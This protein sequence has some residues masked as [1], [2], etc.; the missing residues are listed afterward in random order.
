MY[1]FAYLIGRLT[2]DPEVNKT[3]SGKSVCN[4]TLA[5]QRTYKNADG[6][7]EADFIRC[8]LWDAIAN[9]AAEFCH[10]GDLIAVRGQ[11]RTSSY[12]DSKNEKKHAT[13]LLV[14]RLC[15]LSTKSEEKEVDSKDSEAE[16]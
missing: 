16:N 9:N 10:K 15:F 1:N 11:L 5:V 13:E 2:A 3:E 12:I 6:I 4:I 14:E 7:Y 8:A